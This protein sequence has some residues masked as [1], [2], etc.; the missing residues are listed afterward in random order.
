MNEARSVQTPED[1][2]HAPRT[3]APIAPP[4]APGGGPTDAPRPPADEAID[5]CVGANP[6]W[7]FG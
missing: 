3:A 1:A 5:P 2:G 4:G 7:N 6:F